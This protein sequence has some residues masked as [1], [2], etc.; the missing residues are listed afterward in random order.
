MGKKVKLRSL[1]FEKGFTQRKIS[2]EAR[3]PETKLS[4]FISGR[5]D[6]RPEEIKA[7]ALVL[8]VDQSTLFA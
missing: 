7:L 8:G 4:I 1:I 3:I 6:L 5:G 2:I